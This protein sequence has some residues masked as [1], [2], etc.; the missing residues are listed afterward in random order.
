VQIGD[1]SATHCLQ[2]A[3]TG[4]N[5]SAAC[6]FVCQKI[7]GVRRLSGKTVI[8]SFWACCGAGTLNL[9]INVMQSFGSGG[10]PSAAVWAA[11]AAVVLGVNFARYSVVIPLPSVSGKVLGTNGDDSS[12]LA[13]WYSSGANNAAIAGNIGVQSGLVNLWGVQ[14]EVL[15]PGAPQQPTALEK[16]DP[17]YDLA[18]CQRFYVGGYFSLQAYSEAAYNFAA[19]VY[20]PVTM[21]ATPSI[22]LTN[23]ANFNC[24][25]SSAFSGPGY[26]VV[27]ALT[28]ATS[29]TGVVGNYTASADL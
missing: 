23:S 15:Q 20:F 8:I 7:E 16:P 22:A 9:G 27:T 26:L 2:N 18:N 21:R 11:A 14:L 28:T 13:F 6:N 3:F 24:G 19:S 17:R 10:S 25:A 12:Q 1:E 5:T 29:Q 4:N